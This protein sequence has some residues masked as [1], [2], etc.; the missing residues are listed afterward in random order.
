M[1]GNLRGESPVTKDSQIGETAAMISGMSP[2]LDPDTYL[3]CTSGHAAMIEHGKKLALSWFD[4]TEG[5][6]FII[7]QADAETL[8]MQA[9][10]AMS[11]IELQVFSSLDGVGLTAAVASALAAQG[12]ACNM[13]AAYHHDHVFV[14]ANRAEEAMA[15]LQ[16]VSSI[17]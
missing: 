9:S 15:I 7:R 11:R 6:S 12:I 13:V 14:P 3:F 4:E 8:E 16:N 2:R 10:T 17:S 1:A 5:T